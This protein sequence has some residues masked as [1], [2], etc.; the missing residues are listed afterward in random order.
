MARC[1]RKT[2]L[3]SECPRRTENTPPAPTEREIHRAGGKSCFV[4]SEGCSSR[5]SRMDSSGNGSSNRA[6]EQEGRRVRRLRRQHCSTRDWHPG[7]PQ[8]R[9]APGFRRSWTWRRERKKRSGEWIPGPLGEARS[10]AR[11]GSCRHSER[12]PGSSPAWSVLGR[13][14]P[15]VERALLKATLRVGVTRADG[16]TEAER[17]LKFFLP[18]KPTTK[19]R[20]KREKKERKKRKKKKEKDFQEHVQPR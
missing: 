1:R 9:R 11:A 4:G 3:V 8:S 13:S 20:K 17:A 10:S 19:K 7:G 2:Q 5:S 18:Q 6:D 12:R 15:L 16:V 14:R